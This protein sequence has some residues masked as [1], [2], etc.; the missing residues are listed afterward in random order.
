[1]VAQVTNPQGTKKLSTAVQKE[2]RRIINIYINRSHC[3]AHDVVVLN[4]HVYFI[5]DKSLNPANVGTVG[6][7][8][9][10]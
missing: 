7:P 10:L 5:F 9:H 3:H 1:V 8:F 4:S 2:P 6:S